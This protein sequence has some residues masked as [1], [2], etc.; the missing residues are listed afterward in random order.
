MIVVYTTF[1]LK[2]GADREA[3][4]AADKTMQ[5]EVFHQ[6]KT[7]IRRTV[8]YNPEHNEWIVVLFFWDNGED[9][10]MHSEAFATHPLVQA[11]GEFVDADSVVGRAYTDIGG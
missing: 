1:K 3:F 7:F 5:E 2:A 4:L 11:T 8:A 10:E 6:M 9:L